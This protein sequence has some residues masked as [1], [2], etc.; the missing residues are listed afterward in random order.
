MPRAVE[1][2]EVYR[3]EAR[4]RVE[5]GAVTEQDRQDIHHDLVHE[6]SLQA[7]AGHV[8][9]EDLQVLPACGL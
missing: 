9:A 6:P 8:G 4:G 3:R 1:R 7:L 2:F 5:P